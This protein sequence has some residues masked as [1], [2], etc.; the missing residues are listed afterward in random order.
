MIPTQR[1][2]LLRTRD[3]QGRLRRIYALDAAKYSD[4]SSEATQFQGAK[5]DAGEH[6]SIEAAGVGVAQRGMIAAEQGDVVG[7]LVLGS[8]AE[9]E[10]GA[11][12]DDTFVEEMR[13]VSVPGDLAEADDDADFGQRCDLCGEVGGTVADLL[14][15]GFVA[16][17]GAADD[18]ANPDLAQFEAVVAADGG[19]FAGQAELMEDRVH[20][21]SGA[22]AGEGAARPIGSV[23]SGCEAQDE[24]AGVGVAESGNGFGPVFLVAIGLATDFADAAD[25]V[26]EPGTAGATGDGLLQLIENGKERFGSWPPGAHE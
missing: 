12:L 20:E 24:D 10:G 6:G 1:D 18:R 25:V 9:G 19:G 11:T 2:R 13:K 15:R 23:G 3:V 21:V 7:Q 5:E 14:R 17:R 16:G 26:D 22:I 4:A 8:V